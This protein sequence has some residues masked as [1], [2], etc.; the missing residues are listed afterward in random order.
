MAT[1]RVTADANEKRVSSPA[2]KSKAAAKPAVKAAE[3]L[4]K[5]VA[6]TPRAKT[7]PHHDAQS[8]GVKKRKAEKRDKVVRDSF[9]MPKHDFEKITELKAACLK[10]GVVVKKS[11]L[12]RAGLAAL[13]A[14]SEKKL[15]AV[16]A[17][18]EAVKTGRPATHSH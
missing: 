6:E 14:M 8:A 12:L 9:T 18:V 2:R 11:E 7:A 10:N 1:S 4:A 17:S 16:V 13:A 3:K 5:P 15:L